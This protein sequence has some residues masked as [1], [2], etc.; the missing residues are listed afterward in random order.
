MS[1]YWYPFRVL[2]PLL[3]GQGKPQR[4]NRG[5]P[6]HLRTDDFLPDSTF[7]NAQARSLFDKKFKLW[8]LDAIERVEIAV[9]A[10]IALTLGRHDVFAHTNPR[11]FRL[12]YNTPNFQNRTKHQQWLDKFEEA[13][14]RSKDEFV[15]HHEQKYGSRS[16][17]PIWIA[18]ELWDFGRLSHFYS[19]LETQYRVS[20]ATRYCDFSSRCLGNLA[21][22]LEL[23]SQRHRPS[24]ALVELE[25]GRQSGVATTRDDA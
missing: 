4:D 23:R 18:I 24:W 25:P 2:A 7:E 13:V 16:P 19:G 1:A 17:L 9:R 5:N 3:D 20:V 10:E 22:Q 15:V 8:L 11:F 6:L 14:R 12:G 21:H